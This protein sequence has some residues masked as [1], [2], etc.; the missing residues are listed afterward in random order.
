MADCSSRVWQAPPLDQP[1]SAACPVAVSVD[2]PEMVDPCA[3]QLETIFDVVQRADVSRLKAMIETHGPSILDSHDGEGRTPLLL[4][5]FLG[6]VGVVGFLLAAHPSLVTQSDGDAQRRGLAVHYAAW[7]GSLGLLQHLAT[8][9]RLCLRERDGVGNSPFLYAVYGG[10]LIC[11]QFLVR[12]A[13]DSLGDRNSKGHSA[14]IQAA[15]GGH[16]AVSAWLLERGARLDERDDAGNTPLLFAG[17]GG[18]LDMV[19]WLLAHGAGLQETSASGHTLLL[20]AANAGQLDV[21]SWLVEQCSIPLNQ[22]NNNGDSALLLAAFGGHAALLCYLL[23][24]GAAAHERNH[25]GLD[26]M[27]SACNGGHR[28]IV[29]PYSS[30]FEINRQ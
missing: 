20:S 22:R 6:H 7:G 15:C 2:S 23:D 3:H 28:H 19:Q 30:C 17:W 13:P 10:H 1:A 18:H 16:Q 12:L 21:V 9:H 25:D 5:C 11:A 26:P 24:H 8:H 29:R 14:M 4:A 27:L